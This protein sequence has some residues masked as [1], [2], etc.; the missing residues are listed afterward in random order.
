MHE[1]VCAME[2]NATKG[3]TIKS[4]KTAFAI[5]ELIAETDR[6]SVSE[7]AAEVGCSRSTAHYH[8]KTL[9][10]DRYVIRD[11]EGLRLGLRVARLGDLSL[12]EN[13]LHGIVEKTT[14][15]LAAETDATAHVAVKEDD[16]IVWLYRSS[17]TESTNLQTEVGRETYMHCT[18]YGQAILAY[19]PEKRVNA[20][21]ESF[22]LPAIT[23][24]TITE[25]DMLEK[26]LEIIR[27]IGFAY[28]VGEFH[29]DMSSIAAPI[30]NKTDTV[31]GAI[32]ITNASDRINNPYKHAKARRFSDE[33]P[34][35]VQKAAR[36]ASDNLSGL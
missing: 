12:R 7:I 32:G 27:E 6:P 26:R 34:S 11:E 5:I 33:L 22:E 2:S 36:I 21:V 14:D 23:D 15:D 1:R 30:F 3:K 28:S 17:D 19:M 10:Q 25:S 35:H 18:A 13:N 16:K 20:L 31:V 8:L 9:Q 4:I 29:R 24:Q